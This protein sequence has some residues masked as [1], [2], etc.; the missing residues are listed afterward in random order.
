MTVSYP[1]QNENVRLQTTALSL[2]PTEKFLVKEVAH[3]SVSNLI[4]AAT[5]AMLSQSAE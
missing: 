2:S 4:L 5:V 3:P 1:Q